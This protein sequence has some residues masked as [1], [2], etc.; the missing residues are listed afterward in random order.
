MSGKYF[1]RYEDFLLPNYNGY[2][3]YNSI[4][5]L[6]SLFGIKSAN[7]PLN[8]DLNEFIEKNNKVVFFLTDG[9]G[10]NQ[11]KNIEKNIPFLRLLSK[12]GK[13]FPITS[14]FP[15]TTA[16]SLTTVATGLTPRDHGLFE[17]NLYFDE[18]AEVIQTIPFSP[19]GRR[20]KEGSL[21]EKGA[22]PKLIINKDRIFKILEDNGVNS[23]IFHNQ[24]LANTVYSNLVSN[25]AEKIDYR[26]LSDLIVSIYNVLVR[27]KGPAF[28]YVYWSGI[29][30][31]GHKFGPDSLQYEV[32][33]RIFFES[34]YNDLIKRVPP[35][36]ANNILFALTSDHGQVEINPKETV[37]L[38]KDSVILEALETGLN[39]NI[40]L[41]WGS[42]R[43]VFLRVKK[44][45]IE[46][47]IIYINKKYGKICKAIKTEE[48]IKMGIFG[49]GSDEFLQRI[50]NI[51]LLPYKGKTVWFEHIKGELVEFKGHHGGMSE[52]EMKIPFAI[53]RFKDLV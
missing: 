23:Y 3:L 38:N 20:A 52:D 28:L 13:V 46:D 8:F 39:G 29:D 51:I 47:T 12:K 25:G 35:E 44:D 7:K 50:G 43:D 48:A 10:Y 34:I 33:A 1:K 19:M 32:E 18:L 27:E 42:P 15:S 5:T 17:W 6:L 37:Y 14:G 22:D 36:K 40:I 21:L 30:S 31:E 11:Y 41:P 53:A 2:S 16:A 9:F 24:S 4:Y 49:N 45:K 26:Y